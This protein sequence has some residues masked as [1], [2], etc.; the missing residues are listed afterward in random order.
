LSVSGG[1]VRAI[2][3]EGVN[4]I[5]GDFVNVRRR[6]A[7]FEGARILDPLVQ[8][9]T[10]Q[11]LGGSGDTDLVRDV[12]GLVE[13]RV[14]AC[15]LWEISGGGDASK[16]RLELLLLWRRWSRRGTCLLLGRCLYLLPINRL[17]LWSLLLAFAVSSASAS[18][19][20][21]SSSRS[22]LLLL[23]EGRLIW[24]ALNSADLFGLL[25]AAAAQLM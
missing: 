11:V 9:E 19:S 14:E 24:T 10:F 21:S 7:L 17:D 25:S 3:H 6:F 5:E 16:G 15:G 22:S 12:K 13:R 1:R 2:I 4:R 23:L 18:S 20:C 8:L